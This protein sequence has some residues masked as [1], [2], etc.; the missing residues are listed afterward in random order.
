MEIDCTTTGLK[1]IA[2]LVGIQAKN[3]AGRFCEIQIKT[4]GYRILTKRRVDYT[5][6]FS[7]VVK[8]TTVRILLSIVVAKGLHLEHMDVKTTFVYA[9]L[10]EDIYM[11]Q[12]KGYVILEKEH[13]V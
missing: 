10:E 6:I 7:Y 13:M 9:D 3:G 8:L 11:Q 12:Q 5:K 1:G 4:G 2:K